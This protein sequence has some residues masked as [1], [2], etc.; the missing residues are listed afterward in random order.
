MYVDR[1]SDFGSGFNLRV[2]VRMRVEARVRYYVESKCF[3]V[4][5]NFSPRGEI[6]P[7]VR[8]QPYIDTLDASTY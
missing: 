1:R 3:N 8:F 7:E 5:L 6:P 2:R 4:D